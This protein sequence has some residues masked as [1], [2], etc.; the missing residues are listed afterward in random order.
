MVFGVIQMTHLLGISA[1]EDFDHWHSEFRNNESYRA[2]HGENGYQIF[3]SIEDPDEVV[4]IFEWDD[5]EDPRAFFESEEMR[6]RMENA[7]LKG[8]PETTALRLVDQKSH[9]TASA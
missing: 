7:G 4:V 3:Q 9:Q 5:D 6:E 2:D 1:V 8:H